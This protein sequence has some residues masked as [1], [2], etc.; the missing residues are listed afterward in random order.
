MLPCPGKCQTHYAVRASLPQ[1]GRALCQRRAAGGHIVN[2]NDLFSRQIQSGKGAVC[3]L[4]V[5]P[6]GLVLSGLG[7]GGG[8]AGLFESAF[9]RDPRQLSHPLGQ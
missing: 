3:P 5:G 4:D 6:P 2:E 9:H 7:L 8:G 1:G